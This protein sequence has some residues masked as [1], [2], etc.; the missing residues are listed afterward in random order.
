[1]NFILKYAKL[2]NYQS[3]LHFQQSY[4]KQSNEL[5]LLYTQQD[6]LYAPHPL[7]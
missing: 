4:T 2:Q 3:M 5:I 1:M 6:F 7:L